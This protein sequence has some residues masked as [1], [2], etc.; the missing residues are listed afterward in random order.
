MNRKIQILLIED[1]PNRILEFQT[2]IHFHCKFELS[3]ATGSELE[4]LKL[5]EKEIADVV[6]LDLE[7][8]EG[9]GI[10]LAEKMRKLSI[11]QPFVVVTTNNCS[12]SIQ[13][14]LRKELKVD[15]I[16]QKG[17]SSY[18]PNQVLNIVEK[19]YKYHSNDS[20][21]ELNETAILKK[22]ILHEL[23]NIGFSTNYIGTEYITAALL[24]LSE[25]QDKSYQISKTIYPALATQY[26]SDSSNIE[27]AIRMA[28]ERVW[29]S[30]SLLQLSKYY[31]Y[32][33]NNK[34]GRPSNGEFISNMKLWLFGN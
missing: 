1:D 4:G 25:N 5:L 33:V 19:V 32:E 30:S 34:N 12:E 18:T 29:S 17:N 28:I 6:I 24:L 21:D 22:R 14:Y 16:F 13:Q 31:P 26:N 23:E 8:E 11:Q 2:C 9:N 7:L 3:G 20:L 15:F 10:Q 27:K